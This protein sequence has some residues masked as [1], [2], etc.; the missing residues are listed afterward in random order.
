MT[1]LHSEKLNRKIRQ[2]SKP[3]THFTI[4]S[5]LIVI[6]EMPAQHKHHHI[7]FHPRTESDCFYLYAYLILVCSGIFH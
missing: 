4:L 5:N 6:G 1:S 3:F 7:E 2:I